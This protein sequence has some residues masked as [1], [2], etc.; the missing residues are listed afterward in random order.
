MSS[1][2]GYFIGQI[3]DELAAIAHQVDMRGKIG[4]VALNSLLENFFRDVLNLV[5]GWNLVNLNTKRSNEPGLDLGDADAKV[6][7]QI[8]S[9]ASSPKVKKTLEKVT[10][11]HLRVYDRILVLAIGNKQ[12]SYTLDTPDVARTGFSESNIWDMTDLIR[13]AVMMPILKLQDLHRLIMAET[14]RIRVELEVK[15][16]DGK[17]PTSLED[18]VEPKSSVIITDGSVFATSGIGEEIYGGDADDAA[19]DLN[20]F[21][22]AIADLPRISREFLAWMLSWS[23]ERPGAGAWGFHVNADQITRR[24][25]YG[26]TVGELRFLADRGFISY[27]APEEHEFHKSGYWRLNFPGT[28]RDGFDGAFLDFLTTH[29]LDPKSVVVPLDFSFFGKPP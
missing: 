17:F 14:V 1:S 4:D 28:E 13:D 10:A 16:D 11:D 23:E 21:A 3:V 2:R 26:D 5:H 20:G 6:A 7:V 9:S 29:E 22:E 19:R 18:F 27:D 25:R 24:S 8:T 15:G 12:G